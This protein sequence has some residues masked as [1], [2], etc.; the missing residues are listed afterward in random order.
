MRE[1]ERAAMPNEM[2][3]PISDRVLALCDLVETVVPRLVATL[4][5]L[6]AEC[7]TKA[8]DL[9]VSPAQWRAL[10]LEEREELL[11]RWRRTFGRRKGWT[12]RDIPS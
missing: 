3:D 5:R 4:T 9:G 11:A 1:L 6:T 12:K 8:A 2:R 7:H 10:S